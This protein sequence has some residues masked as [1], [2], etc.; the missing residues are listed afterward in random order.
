MKNQNWLDYSTLTNF[1]RCPRMHYWRMHHHITT[2][3]IALKFGKAFHDGMAVWNMT[4]D[5]MASIL[6]FKEAMKDITEEDPKRNL[7]SG[8]EAFLAYFERW[9]DEE[10]ETID[11]EVGFAIELE[12][13][14]GA[15]TFIGKIDRIMD[16][17]SM[18]IG[19]MEHKTTTIA[20]DGWLNRADPNLQ[21]DGYITA[22]STLYGKRPFGGV[23]DVIHIHEK[24][25][26]RKPAMRII[27]TK[28]DAD[29]WSANMASWYDKII[30]CDEQ[31]FHPKN[32]EICRPIIGY[33]CNYQELC[34]LYPNP[35]GL[36]EITVPGKY[37][38][39]PWHPLEHIEIK[40]GT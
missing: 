10:Y 36:E 20:G 19:I 11:V 1:M 33:S 23:L 2:D 14:H 15:F 25:I 24:P 13:H 39:Q 30:D 27:K 31:N 29:D 17:P 16:S 28:W 40:G 4:K 26:S 8:V 3:G 12:S 7:T 32:T 37:I 21:M 34:S 35:Y 18:G 5:S 38:I 6:K 22:L 9:K